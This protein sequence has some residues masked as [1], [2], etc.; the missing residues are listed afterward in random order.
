MTKRH[1]PSEGGVNISHLIHSI[2]PYNGVL[3]SHNESGGSKERFSN[4]RR[5]TPPLRNQSNE[6]N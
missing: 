6:E 5:Q 4:G 2:S 3:L 1:D